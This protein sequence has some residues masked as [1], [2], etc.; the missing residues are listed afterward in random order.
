[1][2]LYLISQTV[3]QNY[4][5]YDSAVVVAETEQEARNMLPEKW[6]RL[7]DNDMEYD[8]GEWCKPE[9][10]KVKLVGVAAEGV[11]GTVVASFNAG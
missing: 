4:D 5:T 11:T 6:A 3:N 8:L 7:P 2:N 1:M 10:V 9:D